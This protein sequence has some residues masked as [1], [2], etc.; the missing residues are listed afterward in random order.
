MTHFLTDAN[1]TQKRLIIQKIG[2]P[3]NL[4][5]PRS[6]GGLV[7]G[8][9]ETLLRQQMQCCSAGL[10]GP[11][12]ASVC[13]DWAACGA[14]AAPA[15]TSLSGAPKH[16][17]SP[18]YTVSPESSARTAR[19]LRKRGKSH[20]TAE[21]GQRW[22]T[23]Q[24]FLMRKVKLLTAKMLMIVVV[25]VPVKCDV[26]GW[27]GEFT[28]LHSHDGFFLDCFNSTWAAFV[29][30]ALWQTGKKMNNKKHAIGRKVTWGRNPGFHLLISSFNSFL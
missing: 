23:G 1:Y 24:I 29:S 6:S 28:E 13:Q 26:V 16:S 14:A 30:H 5:C 18:P 21:D 4:T 8:S 9:R 27:E 2:Y 19:D 15:R 11:V 17:V 25:S 12:G 7:C 22:G 3:S 10:R 20:R